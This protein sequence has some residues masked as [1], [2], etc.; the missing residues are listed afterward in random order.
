MTSSA[1]NEELQG[2]DKA[3]QF[4]PPRSSLLLT[5][6]TT[7]KHNDDKSC[8]NADVFDDDSVPNVSDDRG[9]QSYNVNSVHEGNMTKDIEFLSLEELV[10]DSVASSSFDLKRHII[11]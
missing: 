4:S 7:D 11:R 2:H 6:T 5:I 1:N 3:T 10:F 8:I 9:D